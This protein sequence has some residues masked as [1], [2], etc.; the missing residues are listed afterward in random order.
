MRVPT[1]LPAADLAGAEAV[2]STTRAVRRR[3]DADGPVDPG[4]LR[5]CLELAGQAP[6]AGDRQPLRWVVVTDKDT[7]AALGEIYRAACA[8]FDADRPPVSD[9]T[10]RRLRAASTDLAIRMGSL[11]ALVLACTTEPAPTEATGTV[12]A[13]SWGSVLPAVWSLQQA[14]RAYGLGSC[15][16]TVRPAR[17]DKFRALTKI[18]REWTLAALLPVA[19]ITGDTL[20]P[21]PRRELEEIVTWI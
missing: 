20:S 7:R 2:L 6:S 1:T 16:T 10:T 3:L 12:A 21:A 15:P 13:R 8:S 5:Q 14:L 11:P 18:P 17:A 19:P 4:V 9:E